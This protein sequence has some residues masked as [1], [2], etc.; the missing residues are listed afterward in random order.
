MKHGAALAP[1]VSHAT[2]PEHDAAVLV[3]EQGVAA[4]RYLSL[5]RLATARTPTFPACAPCLP[6][7]AGASAD[8]ELP[9]PAATRAPTIEENL[10]EQVPTRSKPRTHDYVDRGGAFATV[11]QQAKSTGLQI[12]FHM[13]EVPQPTISMLFLQALRISH[14]PPQGS[15]LSGAEIKVQIIEFCI[16]V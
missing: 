11:P 4:L 3:A 10:A 6:I 14:R 7:W 2:R 13:Y 9:W 8:R 5:C 12:C 15:A 1:M 16:Q